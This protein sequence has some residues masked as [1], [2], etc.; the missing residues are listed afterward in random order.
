LEIK[1][2]EEVVVANPEDLEARLAIAQLYYENGDYSKAI[3]YAEPV[4]KARPDD[5]ATLFLLGIVYSETGQTE[6]AVASLER[7]V[8]IRQE[9]PMAQVDRVLEASL[10]YL[11]ANYLKLNQV[12]EAIKVLEGALDIDGTDAD[13]F[14]QL[15]VAYHQKGENERSVEAYKNAVRFVPDFSEA[16]VGMATAYDALGMPSNALYAQGMTS[17]SKEEYGQ[18]QQYLERAAQDLPDFVP[19]YL[20]LALVYEQQGDLGRAR[21]NVEHILELEPDNFNANVISGRLGSPD[22][23]S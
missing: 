8:E 23:E 14:Y 21:S 17:F 15:G 9:S 4:L 12:D 1:H 22:N 5:P 13:A 16:Y 7:L 11:G 2:L 10:Y 3:Q 18:A 6:I 19:V 20:G